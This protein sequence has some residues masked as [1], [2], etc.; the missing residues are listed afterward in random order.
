MKPTLPAN[1]NWCDERIIRR[2]KSRQ[3]A[4]T[5]WRPASATNLP[6]R[7]CAAQP[8]VGRRQEANPGFRHPP[9]TNPERVVQITRRKT[10][11]AY[12]WNAFKETHLGSAA[13]V[14]AWVETHAT[15]NAIERIP[16]EGRS[17]ILVPGIRRHAQ[18]RT[19][20]RPRKLGAGRPQNRPG[21]VHSRC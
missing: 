3:M 20:R 9:C 13:F 4:F 12:F 18:K 16:A 10:P 8:R 21:P 15:T 19:R 5:S 17:E 14:V 7:G 11:S 6:R 1:A 2:D